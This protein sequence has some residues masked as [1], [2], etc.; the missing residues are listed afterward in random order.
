MGRWALL[1]EAREV[2]TTPERLQVLA[3]DADRAVRNAALKNP[4]LPNRPVLLRAHLGEALASTELEWL[5]NLGA[6]GQEVAAR[7][8]ATPDRVLLELAMKGQLKAVL[9]GRHIRKAAWF[10]EQARSDPALM[11]VLSEEASVGWVIR[12][13]AYELLKFMPPQETVAQGAPVQPEGPA[14]QAGPAPLVGL[15]PVLPLRAR[16]LDR[17]HAYSLS[18]QEA[19]ELTSTPALRRLAARHPQTPARLLEWL[20]TEQPSGPARETLLAQLSSAQLDEETLRHFALHR[21]WEFRAGVA[22]NP[23]LSV[24]LLELLTRDADSLVRAASA[25]HPEMSPAMLGHLAGD[26]SVLVREAVAAHPSARP[27]VLTRLAQDEEWEVRLNVSR[28]P[29]CDP[30]TLDLLAHAPEV[31]IREAVAA[32]LLVRREVLA[33][34]ARDPNERV[35]SVARLRLP[36]V[37]QETRVAAAGSKR[38]NIKLALAAQGDTSGEVLLALSSDR[39]SAVRA[40]AGLHPQLAYQARQR[41]REDPDPQVRRVARAA[42]ST[43]TGDELSALP[44]FDT[45]VKLALSRNGATPPGVLDLLSDDTQDAVRS[46]V[47]LHPATP[48]TGLTRRLPELQ[49]RPLI[50]Q[51]PRYQGPLRLQMHAQELHE[52]AQAHASDE[53]IQALMA[54]DSVDVRSVLARHA[55]TPLDLQ[56][57]L[58]TDPD[59]RVRAALLEREV[60]AAE[61][62]MILVRDAALEVRS[63]LI[64]LPELEERTMTELLSQPNLDLTALLALA[65][66]PN[67]TPHVMDAFAAHLTLQART[68]AARHP[69]LS[70]S[71]L[72]RLAADPQEE[73]RQLVAAHPAAPPE[74]LHLLAQRAE[75]RQAVVLH[76]STRGDTLETLAYDAGYARAVRLPTTPRV[77]DVLRTY[78]LRRASQRA[79]PQMTLL[80]G[81]IHHPNATARAVRFASRLNHPEVASAVLAW[82]AAH[83]PGPVGERRE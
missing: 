28:H 65:A 59:P 77:F 66:H 47:M 67:V 71:S 64:K 36:N 69:L 19:E 73:V 53:T 5:S 12:R 61:I 25:E 75:H 56:T 35:A 32:N 82:R 57:V 16:L 50:R 31:P 4:G 38:R 21:D 24:P 76:P 9:K 72:N 1:K 18:E 58:A 20:D 63:A 54:S 17:K 74:A 14:P 83:P 30:E 68:I 33:G 10:L 79:F 7:N 37:S 2:Q 23:L 52:A 44:R 40:L 15:P 22:P 11:K 81:I 49:L 8:I 78:L 39:S 48:V 45:R 27:E 3:T 80:L 60:V 13:Q 70:G 42:D 34:L 6:Y 62:Q 46:L 43:A 29:G 26:T 41:L 55:R 51:H